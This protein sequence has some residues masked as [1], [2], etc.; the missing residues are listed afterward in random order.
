MTFAQWF[1]F[2]TVDSR[3]IFLSAT[4]AYLHSVLGDFGGKYSQY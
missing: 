1:H 4:P 2:A 3:G